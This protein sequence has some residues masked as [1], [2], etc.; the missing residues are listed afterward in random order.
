MARRSGAHQRRFRVD[1]PIRSGWKCAADR[2]VP[3]YFKEHCATVAVVIAFSEVL[4]AT[5]TS[6]RI[7]FQVSAA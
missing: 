6:S 7:R 2:S 1:V 5:G 4:A 3:V